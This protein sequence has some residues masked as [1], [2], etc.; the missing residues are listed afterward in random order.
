[1]EE[2]KHYKE[3]DKGEETLLRIGEVAAFF[4]VSVKAIRL[5]EKKGIIKPSKVDDLTG[6]R[7]YTV[8]QVQQLNALVELK[9]LGFS[10]DEIKEIMVGGITNEKLLAALTHKRM[11]WEDI[12]NSAEN[13]IDAIDKITERLSLSKEAMKLQELTEEERAWLLVKMVCVEDLKAQSMLSEAIW[14]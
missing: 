5:Y 2:E 7:Y 4:N 14:L 10:L 9:A 13:K 8:E 12:I 11:A 1:M 3:Q 6:Y